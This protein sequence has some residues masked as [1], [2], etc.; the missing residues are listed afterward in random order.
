ML[1][2]R[3]TTYLI[4]QGYRLAH[5]L[6]WGIYRPEPSARP[7]EDKEFVRPKPDKRLGGRNRATRNAALARAG[8]AVE[9]QRAPRLDARLAD[10]GNWR[11]GPARQAWRNKFREQCKGIEIILCF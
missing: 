6:R 3:I 11:C 10:W 7:P 5:R 1:D 9:R 4:I 2:S 8:S